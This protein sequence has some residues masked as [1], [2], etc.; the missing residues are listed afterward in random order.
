MG[1]RESQVMAHR[2]YALWVELLV[3]ALRAFSMA[4]S[5]VPTP[6]QLRAA[7]GLLGWSQ[8]DLADAAG[9]SRRTIKAMELTPDLAPLPGRPDTIACLIAALSSAGMTFTRG[10][11]VMGVTRAVA[12]PSMS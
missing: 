5:R 8:A 9:V 2:E 12:G 6:A 10:R 11:D 1:R 3:P 7:H 4:E